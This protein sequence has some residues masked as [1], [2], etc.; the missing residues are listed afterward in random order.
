MQVSRDPVAG[1]DVAQASRTFTHSPWTSA[2]AFPGYP[3]PLG[4]PTL[5]RCPQ[6]KKGNAMKNERQ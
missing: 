3:Y 6:L 2:L 4:H 5:D 1:L